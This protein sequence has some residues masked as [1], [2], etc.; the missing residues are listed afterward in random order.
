MPPIAFSNVGRQFL[1]STLHRTRGYYVPVLPNISQPLPLD[2]VPSGHVG[3][4]PI[5]PA[6]QPPTSA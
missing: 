3:Y 6:S 5:G 1:P 2:F 4:D